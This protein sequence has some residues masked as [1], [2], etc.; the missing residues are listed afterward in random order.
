MQARF[1]ELAAQ[2]ARLNRGLADVAA[3]PANPGFE[4]DPASDSSQRVQVVTQGGALHQSAAPR[5]TPSI[6][7]GWRL[8]GNQPG[9]CTLVID[10]ENPHAG[11]GS[12]RLASSVAPASVASET[13]VPKIQ[14]SLMIQASFRASAAGAKVRIW[15]EGNSGGQPYVRRSELSVSTEWQT[16]AVRASDLPAAGLDSARLRFELLT[17]GTL[18]ID[19][20]HIPGETTSKSARLNAQH[21]LLAALQAYREQR[22]ADFARLAGSHWIRESNTVATARLARSSDPPPSGATHSSNAGA[23]ALP[24]ESKLR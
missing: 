1:N 24:S 4:P 17:P 19:E 12:L 14:P 15:I 11:E 7:G 20:L 9:T 18:W 10:R 8:E 21:T 5:D 3:E 23:T 22:Y 13:F 2:L 16:R 6:P